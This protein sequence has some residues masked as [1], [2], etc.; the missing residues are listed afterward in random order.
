MVITSAA[1]MVGCLAGQLGKHFGARVVGLTSTDEKVSYIVNELGFDVGINYRST[2]D[3]DAAI[4]ASCP[5]GVDYFFDNT[6]GDQAEVIR[7][8]LNPGG[9][10][11]QCG[12]VAHYNDS[13]PWGQSA[14][15]HGQFTVHHHVPRYA[16]GRKALADLLGKGVLRYNRT[17]FAGLESAP[18]AFISLLQ[19][20]NIGKFLVKVA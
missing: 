16:A 5:Q 17:E 18:E 14:K 19:G 4:R 9:R 12:L 1:G 7:R 20:R 6:A 8:H 10:V 3:L 13:R 15:F 2:A 11:T